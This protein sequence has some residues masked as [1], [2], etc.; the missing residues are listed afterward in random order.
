[1]V[2]ILC[3]RFYIR[4]YRVVNSFEKLTTLDQDED[5]C[6][7]EEESNIREGASASA[8]FM[9]EDSEDNWPPPS[10]QI[11]RG[12]QPFFELGLPGAM[13]LFFEWLFS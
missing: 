1:M 12:W 10:W 3:R 6:N 5:F 11:L 8:F 9:H 4:K 2:I 7:E 13:S